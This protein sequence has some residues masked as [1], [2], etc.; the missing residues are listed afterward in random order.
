MAPGRGAGTWP[1]SPW[2][3]SRRLRSTWPLFQ[4]RDPGRAGD[5]DFLFSSFF[6]IKGITESMQISKILFH[7]LYFNSIEKKKG[8]FSCLDSEILCQTLIIGNKNI[9]I[10]LLRDASG[11]QKEETCSNLMVARLTCTTIQPLQSWL[12]HKD[13]I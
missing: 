4:T 8:P 1:P 7:K 13:K 2:R 12:F 6:M 9:I 11:R 10:F 5:K 3:G